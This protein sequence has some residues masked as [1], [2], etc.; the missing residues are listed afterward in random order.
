[1]FLVLSTAKSEVNLISSTCKPMCPYTVAL[2]FTK[3]LLFS[4]VGD[5]KWWKEAL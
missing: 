3:K 1:M 2:E 5:I 4:K